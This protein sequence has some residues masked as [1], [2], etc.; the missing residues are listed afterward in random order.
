[1]GAGGAGVRSGPRGSTRVLLLR[2]GQSTWNAERRWQGQ[3]DPALS[4]LGAAQARSAAATLDPATTVRASDLARARRTAELLTPDGA[5]VRVDAR[6]RERHVGAWTGLTQDEIER[7]YPGWLA[8]G[9]RPEDWED[10][11]AVR[12]RA[13]PALG[14]AAAAAADAPVVVVSHGGLIRAVVSGLGAAPW[15]VPN[16]GGVW[17][18][19]DGERLRLG[20]RVSLL[21]GEGPGVDPGRGTP[22]E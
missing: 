19:G 3:A 14:A 20:A 12:A 7:S 10:D 2:H 11:E 8:D 18:E 6:L 15:P 4:E 21:T 16:L 22:S 13:W 1:V 9:R 17:L 5:A